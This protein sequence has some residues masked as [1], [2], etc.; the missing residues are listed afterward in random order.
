MYSQH[1]WLIQKY[2]HF[3]SEIYLGIIFTFS[4]NI[5]KI[6]EFFE[7]IFNFILKNILEM[8]MEIFFRKYNFLSRQTE[9]GWETV[10]SLAYSLAW[11]QPTRYLLIGVG[12]RPRGNFKVKTCSAKM[13]FGNLGWC[14]LP[15]PAKILLKK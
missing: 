6:W 8:N 2:F 1:M 7:H 15:H 11:M 3:Y 14:V 5:S 4:P 13:L 10:H 9:K 12:I